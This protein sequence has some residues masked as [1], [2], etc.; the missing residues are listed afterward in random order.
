MKKFNVE[1][2]DDNASDICAKYIQ[3]MLDNNIMPEN[4]EIEFMLASQEI[5]HFIMIPSE[6]E[7]RFQKNFLKYDEIKTGS[8]FHEYKGSNEMSNREARVFKNKEG[9]YVEFF[10]DGN[11]QKTVPMFEHSESYAESAAEN[12]VF[13]YHES[14]FIS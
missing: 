14:H 5:L 7:A 2:D 4:R 8:L 9:F 6:W 10:I 13:G 1:I 12:W 11:L 3:Y